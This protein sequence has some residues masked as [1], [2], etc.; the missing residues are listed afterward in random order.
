MDNKG[1]KQWVWLALDV[2]TREIV[3][4][5]MGPARRSRSPSFVEFLTSGLPP[6]CSGLHRL[7]DS[8]RG[9]A[10]PANARKAV[11][12]ETGLTSYIERFNNTLRQ[13]VFRLVRKTW[14]NSYVFRESH[15]CHLVF[16]PSSIVR[17]VFI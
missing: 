15:W 17:T 10:M 2:D 16:H 5:Y 9:C 1:N 13:R 14:S 7:L 4:V 8:L 3:G 11:G 6:V 12:K